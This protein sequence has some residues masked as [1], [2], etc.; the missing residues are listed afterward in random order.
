MQLFTAPPGSVNT[1]NTASVLLQ[2]IDTA[3]SYGATG[4]PA[5]IVTVLKKS[6]E[7]LK[8]RKIK[9]RVTEALE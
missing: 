1:S 2:A 3:A 7:F 4:I 5:P 6:I 8:E 9:Q